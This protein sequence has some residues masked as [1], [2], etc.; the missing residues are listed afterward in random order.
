MSSA[1]EISMR[2]PSHKIGQFHEILCAN[3]GRYIGN[4]ILIRDEF[5]VSFS[6]VKYTEFWEAWERQTIHI[7]EKRRQNGVLTILQNL[8]TKA[9]SL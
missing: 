8:F 5:M 4:P 2:I 6:I 9:R 3:D 7:V 1:V